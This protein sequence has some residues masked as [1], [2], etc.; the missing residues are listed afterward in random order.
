MRIYLA[1]LNFQ[2][3]KDDPH[4][5]L[6]SDSPEN[7][8]SFR[9]EACRKRLRSIRANQKAQIGTVELLKEVPNTGGV[10]SYREISRSQG[11]IEARPEGMD[12]VGIT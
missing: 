8:V 3:A 10:E 6:G 4:R 7:G 2:G 11:A 12:E 1:N 9:V 5:S